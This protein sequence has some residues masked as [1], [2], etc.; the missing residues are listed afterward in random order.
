MRIK[1]PVF[2]LAAAW[3]AL[4]VT[5]APVLGDESPAPGKEKA[6]ACLACHQADGN[7]VNPEW[8]KLAGQIPS[9]TVKQLRDFKAGRRAD[10]TMGP[11]ATPLSE[12]DMKDLAAY[13]EHQQ[14]KPGAGKAELLAAGR[15]IYRKGNF[16]SAVTACMGCHGPTGEG[17]KFWETVLAA[18]PAVMAPVITSQHATYVVKQMQAFKSGARNNDVGRVMQIIASRMTD[19]EIEAVAEY[20]ATLP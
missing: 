12:Q 1:L 9:Y 2:V 6:A 20:I 18:P 17:Y 3:A 5:I 19:E 8:P 16:D 15:K 14:I 10:P 7:S 13:Y 11:M 4:T